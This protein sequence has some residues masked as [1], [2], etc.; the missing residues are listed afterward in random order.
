MHARFL[1][2]HFT[3]P[4]FQKVKP[5]LM[6]EGATAQFRDCLSKLI[7]QFSPLRPLSRA[8]P[9]KADSFRFESQCV[10]QSFCSVELLNRFI[11]SEYVMAVTEMASRNEDTIRA[12]SLWLSFS[13]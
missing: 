1:V 9:F 13:F 8:D 6:R 3:L 7:Y 11:V 5:V 10:Y 2:A 12:Q 4:D